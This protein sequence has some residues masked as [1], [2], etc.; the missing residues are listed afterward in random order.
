[1]FSASGRLKSYAFEA[2]N[3]SPN[4]TPAFRFRALGAQSGLA[5]VFDP[6][7]YCHYTSEL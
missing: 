5:Q 1:M 7:L 6:V 3:F 4:E 2:D